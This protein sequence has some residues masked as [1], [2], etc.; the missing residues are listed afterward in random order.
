MT[1]YVHYKVVCNC[2]HTG[3]ITMQENDAPFSRQY[4]N[5]SASDL[6]CVNKT[7]SVVDTFATMS[8]VF[9]HMKPSCP[10][11]GWVLTE[12]DVQS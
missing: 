3:E 9:E 10:E 12:D 4:E 8:Q 1:S 6:N 7:Y 2:G 5:Y 11:C